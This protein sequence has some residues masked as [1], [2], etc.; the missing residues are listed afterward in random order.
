[1]KNEVFIRVILWIL[2]VFFCL[3]NT[4]AFS[5]ERF[6]IVTTE[7]LK[8]MLDA[9]Q[10]GKLDFV[11]VNGLD[12]IVFRDSAIPGSVNIPWS[13]VDENA[14]KLGPDRHKLIITY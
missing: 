2:V 14:S 7:E 1:M 3:F 12:E 11:L 13:N 10:T 9:R 8:Q 5:M 6:G 4:S